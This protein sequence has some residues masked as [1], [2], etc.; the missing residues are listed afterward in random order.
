MTETETRLM[1]LS[2]YPNPVRQARPDTPYRPAH[3]GRSDEDQNGR[4]MPNWTIGLAI[5]MVG[6]LF[7]VQIL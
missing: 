2:H 5:S 1:H 6:A 3:S 7:L 4:S